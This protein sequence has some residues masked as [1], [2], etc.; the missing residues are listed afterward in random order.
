M[1]KNFAITAA[2][3]FVAT[4]A[5]AGGPDISVSKTSGPAVVADGGL[6]NPADV[7]YDNGTLDYLNGL[8]S[9]GVDA[10][11][12]RRS[13]LD[14]FSVPEGGWGV[15]SASS[16]IIWSSGARLV[17][18]DL[19]VQFFEGGGCAPGALVATASTTSYLATERDDLGD[20]FG[21]LIE[22]VDVT[23]DCIDLP[24]GDYYIEMVSVGPEN[25]FM[26]TAPLNGCGE[27]WVNYDDFGGLQPGSA[28][29]GAEYDVVFSIGDCPSSDCLT[30]GVS[31]LATGEIGTWEVNGAAHF[32]QVAIAYGVNEGKTSINNYWKD[33]CAT[34]GIKGVKG[35]RL[36]CVTFADGNGNAR[37][38]ALVPAGAAGVRVLSQAA[39]RGTCPDSCMSNIDD[40]V[41]IEN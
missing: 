24:E 39:M 14:D 34:F 17:G 12:A 41:V 21:R 31:R 32:A 9:A 29:F 10:F 2:A 28:V 6:Q 13:I 23:F 19:E 26:A 18:T 22:Q 1:R 15:G 35:H 8:S 25:C 37:C 3:C 16:L 7:L 30:L 5:F 27:C 11:G 4:A 40:Q 20:L 33:W 36:I 38:E